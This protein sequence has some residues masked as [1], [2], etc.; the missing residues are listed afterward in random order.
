VRKRKRAESFSPS[1]QLDHAEIEALN[2]RLAELAASPLPQ[3]KAS[4][5]L[6]RSKCLDKGKYV[7]IYS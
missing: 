1:R 2:K 7:T 4:K 6:K 5:I 3:P